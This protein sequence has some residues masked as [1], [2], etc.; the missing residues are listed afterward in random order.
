MKKLLIL[1]VPF[2][3]V[4]CEDVGSYSQYETNQPL[5]RQIFLE[6]MNA[7][8]AG[9][10]TTRYNDWDEVVSSCESAAYYQSQ[11]CIAGPCLKVK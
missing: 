4:G 2:L 1:L 6:C 11:Q 5:R 7:L 9:P 8:P 10:I 3:L